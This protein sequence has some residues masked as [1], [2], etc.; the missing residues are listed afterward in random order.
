[1][2]ERIYKLQPDRTL[3]LRGFDGFG[4]AAALHSA[5]KDSFKVSGVFRD[6]ADFAVLVLY[7]A[8]NIYD[9]PSI[10]YLP[11][12][13]FNELNLSF[14]VHYSGLMTID[15]PNYPT[16]DW[17]RLDYATEDGKSDCYCALT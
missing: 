8:D 17:P 2:P 16:I 11:D 7:D 9:H 15:S 3:H 5:T 6:A 12:F 4:A 14:D 13:D 10:R 1:M